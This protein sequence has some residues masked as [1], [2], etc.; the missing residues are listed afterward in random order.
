MRPSQPVR[1][2]TFLRKA[3]RCSTSRRAAVGFALAGIATLRTPRSCSSSFDRSL[4]VAAI[5]GHRP[6]CPAGAVGDPLDRRRE[7]R[8]VGRVADLDVVIEDDTVVVV[9]ELRLVAELDRLAEAALADR[10]G[11]GVVQADQPGGRC[12]AS[13][14]PAGYGSGPRP[15]ELA[16]RSCPGRRT[17]PEPTFTRRLARRQ[18]PLAR[19]APRR[20]PPARRSRRS[21]PA[22]R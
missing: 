8:G 11:V 21:R 2:L 3:R 17:P 12:R 20:R 6:W 19:Y 15:A 10:A 22:R 4:A 13:P 16:A 7:L 9:D 14:R 18:R 5:G 1:H